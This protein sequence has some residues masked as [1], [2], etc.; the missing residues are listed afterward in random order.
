MDNLTDELLDL[1]VS[2][3]SGRQSKSEAQGIGEDEFCPWP[4]GGIL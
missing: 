4:I 2:V 3:A 1:I